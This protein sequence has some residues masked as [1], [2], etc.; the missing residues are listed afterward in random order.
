MNQGRRAHPTI[1][2]SSVNLTHARNE[3]VDRRFERQ[4]P[5]TKSPPRQRGLRFIKPS[6]ARSSSE[7]PSEVLLFMQSQ[8]AYSTQQ[9]SVPTVPT[10]PVKEWKPSGTPRTFRPSPLGTAIMSITALFLTFATPITSLLARPP[11]PAEQG[12]GGGDVLHPNRSTTNAFISAAKQ[13]AKSTV[14]RD[15]FTYY[16]VDVGVNSR[17]AQ[18]GIIQ[19]TWILA[20][21][22]SNPTQV[23]LYDRQYRK[24]PIDPERPS[25]SGVV[26]QHLNPLT[27]SFVED[28]TVVMTPEGYFKEG[29]IP[30]QKGG[31]IS[32]AQ[33]TIFASYYS[34]TEQKMAHKNMPFDSLPSSFKAADL[35]QCFAKIISYP[36]EGLGILIYGNGI[37][38]RW[39][40][41][42]EGKGI[43]SVT[44]TDPNLPKF[45]NKEE[46]ALSYKG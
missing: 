8:G 40:V 14:K 35:Y 41:S 24:N 26:S 13:L 21:S 7:I 39:F 42:L 36:A 43:S 2:P 46:M 10:S 6:S 19:Y 29:F 16:Y 33:N 44:P 37:K 9:P 4:F 1:T 23:Y 11:T 18:N 34:E 38:G 45:L 31:A 12:Q 3:H 20:I 15:G 5:L 25:G 22:D 28:T 30:L 27:G 17:Q 32:I